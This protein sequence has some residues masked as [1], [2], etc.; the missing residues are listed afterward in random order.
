[1]AHQAKGNP[2]IRSAPGAYAKTVATG[3]MPGNS[4]DQRLRLT[5]SAWRHSARRPAV[6]P[7]RHRSA[8]VVDALVSRLSTPGLTG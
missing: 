6:A 2:E 7:D 5:G 1:M 4:P 3:S 8:Q